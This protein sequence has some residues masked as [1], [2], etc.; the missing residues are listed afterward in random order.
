MFVVSPSV[1]EISTCVS[2]V[3]ET[4]TPNAAPPAEALSANQFFALMILAAKGA[5]L[6]TE[7]LIPAQSGP[8]APSTH[9]GLVALAAG[10]APEYC[11]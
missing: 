7:T 6:L 3:G 5:A 4:D 9:A 8:L 1:A 2:S 10:V 11:A